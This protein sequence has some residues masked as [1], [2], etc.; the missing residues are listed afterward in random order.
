MAS[1]FTK[2]YQALQKKMG[3]TNIHA[4]PKIT[5]VVVNVGV[6]KQRDNAA[7]LTAVQ[8]DLAAIT[9][10][11]PHERHARKAVSGFNVRQGNLVGY[12]VT[13]RGKRM[14]DF[15]TRFI[16]VTLP[17]VRDFRGVS[18]G[19][20]DGQGNLSVGLKEHLPFP[21]IHPEQTDVIFG[22]EVTFVTSATN[23]EQGEQLLRALGFPLSSATA[24]EDEVALDTAASRRAREEAKHS[25]AKRGTQDEA[26]AAANPKPKANS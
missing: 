26:P 21:E 5:R 12:R 14:E 18:V 19:S 4:V 22:V 23:N 9:G 1:R 2:E 17:R 20:L 25:Q 7:F 13:L 3:I 11:K 24:Q 15:V 8:R 10:Q 16:N 6:G